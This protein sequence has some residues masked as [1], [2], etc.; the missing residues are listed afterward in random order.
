MWRIGCFGQ[1][2]EPPLHLYRSKSGS[3]A[4]CHRK[5]MVLR[6]S[7]RVALRRKEESF[8]SKKRKEVWGGGLFCLF[9]TICEARN[10][11]AF[12]DDM[13]SIHNIKSFFLC[14]IW[15]ATKLFNVNWFHWLLGLLL[16][17]WLFL[18]PS[19]WQFVSLNWG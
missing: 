18:R 12:E 2:K 7:I 14:F 1:R 8:T 19:F 10:K 6:S 16:R 4:S 5:I 15:S 3:S 17:E 11:T 9:W 13:L